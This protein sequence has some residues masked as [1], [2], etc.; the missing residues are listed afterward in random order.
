MLYEISANV[1]SHLFQGAVMA[2]P[3]PLLPPPPPVLRV[4]GLR[5][6]DKF[7]TSKCVYTVVG[8]IQAVD[9]KNPGMSD[10]I[11]RFQHP[12]GQIR[13]AK[14]VK[15][16]N[17]AQLERANAE[18]A[19]MKQLSDAGGSSHINHLFEFYYPAG[20]THATFIV[21]YCNQDT[22]MN[23]IKICEDAGQLME[24]RFCWHVLGQVAAALSMCHYGIKDPLKTQYKLQAWDT[25]VH[26]DL[27]PQ[28]IFVTTLP[29]SIT[30]DFM[31]PP[32][33]PRRLRLCCL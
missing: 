22:L 17:A 29:A 20:A 12:N 28:N 21:E 11:Y 13:V 24:E 19:H 31:G 3:P 33:R 25:I 15:V 32:P 30:E 23:N 4:R 14:Q 27:K 8:V 1:P 9:P 6:G 26:L 2:A 18:Q 16:S 5:I 10:G 7:Q